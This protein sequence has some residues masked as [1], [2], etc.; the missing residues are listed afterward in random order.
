M[1]TTTTERELTHAEQNA[2]A[3]AE[4]I[5]AAHEAYEFC[6]SGTAKEGR[7]LSRE[8][9]QILREMEYDGTNHQDVVEAIAN[10]T[11]EAPLS[12]DVR[13]GWSTPGQLIAEDFQILLSTGGPALRIVGELSHHLEPRRAR[14]E[15]QD[16]G[17]RW[18][19]WADVDPDALLW[20]ASHFWFGDA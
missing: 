10:Q 9:K 8:A 12:V 19:E 13:S 5:E 1:T 11:R 16:W 3:H 20:F 15:H 4:A 14:L 7:D 2:K 18:T 17:T 6:D